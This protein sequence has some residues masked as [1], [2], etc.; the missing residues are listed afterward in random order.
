MAKTITIRLD[1][2]TYEKMKRFAEAERRPISN[3]IQHATLN[4]IDRVLFVDNPEIAEILGDRNLITKLR[5]GSKD[6][7][8]KR[9]KFV[10]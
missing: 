10:A 1:E 9:G 4:Y 6:A 8:E 5:H 2:E 7:K 3:F